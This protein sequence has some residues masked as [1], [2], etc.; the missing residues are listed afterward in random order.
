MKKILFI[1]SFITLGLCGFSQENANYDYKM[2]YESTWATYSAPA[3]TYATSATDSIWYYTVLKEADAN[4]KTYIK[5]S[6]DSI[7]GADQV[8]DFYYQ[9]KTWYSD[10]FANVD[11]VT[12]SLGADTTFTFTN[13]TA[14]QARYH[15]VYAKSR[16]KGFI[17]QI[18][19]LS[20]LFRK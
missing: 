17:F 9:T 12:W 14:S 8:V 10:D 7:S 20:T 16:L 11:T 18:D 13:A 4:V 6:A 5:V 19:E 15:R 2:G 1:L 3:T